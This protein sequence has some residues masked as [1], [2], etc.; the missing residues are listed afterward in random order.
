MATH[1]AAVT[2]SPGPEPRLKRKAWKALQ[3]HYKEV[4]ALH[5]RNLFADDPQRGERMT[6]EAAG[7]F[8]DYSKN[9]ITDET[10]GFSSGLPKR[11]ACDR[12]SMP[13]FGEK[14]ST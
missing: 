13:C 11:R 1:A 10:V 14:R 6:A 7:L 5:L 12:A 4:R 3:S 2:G 9:R 8:L